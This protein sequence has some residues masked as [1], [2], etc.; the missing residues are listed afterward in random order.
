MKDFI[1]TWR[2]W[3]KAP[4][5]LAIGD[6]VVFGTISDHIRVYRPA[7]LTNR[8]EPPAVPPR[9]V[10]NRIK[11]ANRYKGGGMTRRISPLWFFNVER[12]HGEWWRDA[13]RVI[14]LEGDARL[15]S[16]FETPFFFFFFLSYIVCLYNHKRSS[17]TQKIRFMVAKGRIYQYI[18][19]F[20]ISQYLAASQ[21]QH[22]RTC[23][24]AFLIRMNTTKN[25]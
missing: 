23:I 10:L 14:L 21:F 19:P 13:S 5:R 25:M 1:V 9:V 8:S 11:K 7:D 24:W 12:F 17:W 22:F 16:L 4:F 2:G 18:R 15:N 20:S 3:S 6:A